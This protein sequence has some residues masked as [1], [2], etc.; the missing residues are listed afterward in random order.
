MDRLGQVAA[1]RHEKYAA[2][3]EYEENSGSSL[4]RLQATRL[5]CMLGIACLTESWYKTDFKPLTNNQK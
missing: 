1:L 2:K 4:P 3:I 5:S